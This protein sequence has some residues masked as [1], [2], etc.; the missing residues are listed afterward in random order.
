M[1]RIIELQSV[2]RIFDSS[3]A[4]IEALVN[5]DLFVD[6][7]EFVSILGPSGCGK[8]TLLKIIAGLDDDYSGRVL[9]NGHDIIGLKPS[10]CFMHQKDLLLPWKTVIDNVT[11]PLELRGITKKERD[12]CAAAYMEEFGLA[13]FE[14]M[15]PKQLSGGMRQRAALLR[16]FLCEGDVFLMDEPFASLDA[17]TRF[18]MREWLLN[19]WDHHK[20][21]VIFVTHDIEEAIFL[22][23]RIY[24]LSE[25]PA[26]V[27]HVIDVGLKRPRSRDVFEDAGFNCLRRRVQDAL[28]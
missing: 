24:I 6:S 28:Q 17:L 4:N 2:S 3:Q 18:R 5:I 15:Y 8:S 27:A 1:D 20:K 7:N 14:K 26:T 9:V 10:V 11:L 13:G 22:S 21:A 23:D 25:R 19:L 12:E 16:T